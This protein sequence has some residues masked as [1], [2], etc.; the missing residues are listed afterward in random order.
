MTTARAFAPAKI[1]LTLHVTDQRADGY[2]LLDSLVVFADIGDWIS[3]A[4]LDRLQLQVVGPMA[5]GVPNGDTNLV[6]RAARLAGVTE[7]DIT[8]EKHL[9]MASGIG[10]GSSDAA[11]VLRALAQSHGVSVP[12]N[13]LSLGAD[14]PVCLAAKTARMSGI[15][16]D[17]LIIETVPA[18]PAVLVNPGHAISTPE[19]FNAL[20]LCDGVSMAEIPVFA[21]VADCVDW[22]RHQRNDM[23]PAALKLA[24]VIGDVLVALDQSGA[25]FARMSGSG[26]TCFG[27]YESETAAHKAA[28]ALRVGNTDW[29]V[30]PTVLSA[31]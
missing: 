2:H 30:Q 23:Q 27:L 19:V 4:S 8:L 22:L 3:V 6:L 24:P 12:D 5:A 1:N 14:L 16:E 9:P 10:G 20:E 28:K 7:A 21:D 15:G 13:V 31:T 18:L 11:A 29:W 25:I 17:I 26:A